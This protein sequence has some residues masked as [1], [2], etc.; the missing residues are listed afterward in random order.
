MCDV[1]TVSRVEMYLSMKADV[2]AYCVKESRF[3]FAPRRDDCE[4]YSQQT[5]CALKGPVE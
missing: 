3:T 4:F 1:W 5:F 2:L